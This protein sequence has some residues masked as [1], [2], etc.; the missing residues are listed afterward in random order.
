LNAGKTALGNEDA[1]GAR[2]ALQSLNDMRTILEQE[3]ALRIV[4]R[5]GEKSGVWRVPDVN[6]RARNYYIV[7]EAVDPTGRV[8]TVPVTSEETDKT[9]HVT[10]WGLRVDEE[11]FQQVARD[12][13]DN[14]IIERDR[15]GYKRRGRLV[16]EYEMRTSG[17]AITHW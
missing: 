8:L 9:E 13:Q 5:A 12:K 10:R 17:A 6:T 11:T 15:F 4:N 16:P 3:Y 1:R 7:V 14:G 2:E